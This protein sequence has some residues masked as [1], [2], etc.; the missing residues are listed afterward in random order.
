MPVQRGTSYTNIRARIEVLAEA[1]IRNDAALYLAG[2]ENMRGRTRRFGTIASLPGLRKGKRYEEAEWKE[3]S[4]YQR[5]V[6]GFRDDVA[7]GII[8]DAR[9]NH[10]SKD[11]LAYAVQDA[12]LSVRGKLIGE[13]IRT[14]PKTVK[15]DFDADKVRYLARCLYR[16]GYTH[17]TILD[18]IRD[19]Y[20]TKNGHRS[21][22]DVDPKLR[23]RIMRIDAALIQRPLSDV[24]RE[25]PGADDIDY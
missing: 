18:R 4:D 6:G 8:E 12:L 25:V 19:S 15:D 13:L 24:R 1:R 3:E 2:R 16:S 10:M 21:W 5:R 17:S 23:A 9:R 22:S 7:R 14:L 20:G 11:T